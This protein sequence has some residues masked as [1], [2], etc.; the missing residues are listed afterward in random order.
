MYG[1]DQMF[2]RKTMDY[3]P[4]PLIVCLTFY[5]IRHRIVP[6]LLL[7]MYMERFTFGHYLLTPLLTFKQRLKMHLFRLSYHGLIFYLCRLHC[8][9]F[10]ALF[11]A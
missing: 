2:L 8:F 6:F 3:G 1:N 7:C 11:A 5:C 10:V 4:P 9:L